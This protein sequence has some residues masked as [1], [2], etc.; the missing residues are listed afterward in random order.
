MK[1]I[2]IQE[3]FFSVYVHLVGNLV[4]L[5][6]GIDA[7]NVALNGFVKTV[8]TTVIT[9]LADVSLVLE[10]SRSN[11][12]THQHSDSHRANSSRNRRNS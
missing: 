4:A 7:M 2:D 6:A 12:I 3:D 1:T 10:F 8:K 11:R 9:G 5:N